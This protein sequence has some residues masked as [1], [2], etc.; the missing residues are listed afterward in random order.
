MVDKDLVRSRLLKLEEYIN[1]LKEYQNIKFV[2][3]QNDKLIKRF[4]ERTLQLAIESCLDIGNHIISDERLGTADT[5]ADIIRILAENDIIKRNVEQYIKMSKFRNVIV[6]DYA[7][8]DDKVIY[9]ILTNNLK[10][11]EI[12]FNWYREYIN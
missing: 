8:V 10:D 12:L 4:V 2:K 3:Y 9:Q 6:H 5:N 7:T 1:D 11:I